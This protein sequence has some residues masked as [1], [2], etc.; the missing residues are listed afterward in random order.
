MEFPNKQCELDPLPLSMLKECL[1]VIL[2]HLTK[3][4][5]LS[6]MLGDIPVELKMAIIRPL[7][8]KIGLEPQ[9]KNYRPVSNLSFLSKL[10]EKIVAKQFVDHMIRN[11]LM[12]PLQSAYEKDHSTETA[13]LKVQN[14]LLMDIDKGNVAV[15]ILLDLSAAFDTIDHDI[16]LILDR[17]NRNFQAFRVQPSNG[18]DPTY[19]TGNK[20]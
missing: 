9:F 18:L 16:G 4:V 12:D 1:P 14:H 3:I 11:K 10:I 6:L 13:L 7:L 15:L 20:L 2:S 17:I 5:N 19:L 8:K